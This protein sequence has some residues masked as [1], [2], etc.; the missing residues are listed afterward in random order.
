[1]DRV[2]KFYELEGQRRY[3]LRQQSMH[4]EA[5]YSYG[6]LG[7]NGAGKST[8]IRLLAGLELPDSGTIRRDLRV[9]WPLGFAS[10][11][12][13]LM[14]GREN[15]KFVSRAYGED[16]KRVLKFVSD[17]SELGIYLNQPVKT[18]SSGMIARLAFG[19]SM[20]IEFDCYLIDEIVSVGDARFQQRCEDVFKERRKRASLIMVSHDMNMISRFCDRAMVLVDGELLAF[21]SVD[22]AIGVYMRLNK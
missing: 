15:L 18:Y 2:D 9:S 11:F 6:L 22:D 12:N 14:S 21:A 1:M 8:T 10:G 4:F 3:I 17:F 13:Y 20:A 7:V 19:L 16:P 5:G